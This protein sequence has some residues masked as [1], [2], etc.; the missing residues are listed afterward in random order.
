LANS[1]DWHRQLIAIIFLP[2]VALGCATTPAM[3]TWTQQQGGV[4]ADARLVR[5]QSIAKNLAS[6]C[7]GIPITI[8]VLASD[9]PCAYGWP[10]G[11]IFVTRGLMDMLDDDELTAAIAHEMGHLL[12]DGRLHTI[13]ALQGYAMDGDRESRADAAGTA[14]LQA[15][16]L[17]PVV[18]IHMLQKV[19]ASPLVPSQYK[20]ALQQRIAILSH[21]YANS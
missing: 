19:E 20:L 11:H 15:R 9:T 18:M 14:L 12:S 16:G 21:R 8:H 1:V 5:A 3:Q 6:Y 17:G 10:T 2:L 4:I 7:Q 13:A